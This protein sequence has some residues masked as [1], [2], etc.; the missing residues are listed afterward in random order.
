MKQSLPLTFDTPKV[1]LST[2]SKHGIVQ[3]WKLE[4]RR[5]FLARFQKFL[6]SLGW[7]TALRFYERGNRQSESIGRRDETPRQTTSQL[8]ERRVCN[9]IRTIENWVSKFFCLISRYRSVRLLEKWKREYWWHIFGV[10]K[11]WKLSKFLLNGTRVNSE[12]SVHL[13]LI[14]TTRLHVW[15]ASAGN[16]NNAL[17]RNI[18]Q[19]HSIRFL[20]TLHQKRGCDSGYKW[21]SQEW[22]PQQDLRFQKPSAMG[23]FM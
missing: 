3:P 1:Y 4:I 11:T 21:V 8:F 20:Y 15:L 18:W 12:P 10:P 7:L 22:F 19:Q 6:W 9:E 17:S 14:G 23:H 13:G 2:W 5:V 16:R